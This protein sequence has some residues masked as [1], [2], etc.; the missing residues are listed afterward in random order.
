M[1]LNFKKETQI[2]QLQKIKNKFRQ[3]PWGEISYLDYKKIE[4]GK[5]E[6]DEINRYCKKKNNLVRFSLGF[7]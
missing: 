2:F 1:Q 6:F 5:K 7:G 3:T 4:F